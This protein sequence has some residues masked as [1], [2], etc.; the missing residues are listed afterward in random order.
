MSVRVPTWAFGPMLVL[1]LPVAPILMLVYIMG[2]IRL[3]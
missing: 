2:G 3:F 1:A